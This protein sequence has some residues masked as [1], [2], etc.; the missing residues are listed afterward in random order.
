MLKNIKKSIKY[1]IIVL[2]VFIMLPTVLY[3]LLQTSSVQTFLVKRI[4]SHFSNQIKSTISIGSIE[5]RFFNKLSI[6][7]LLIKDRNNDTLIYSWKVMLGIKR[8]DFKKKSFRLGRV[9]LIKPV[10][11]FI[12]DSSGM[13][14]LTW[15]LNLLKNP[16]DTIKK[17]GSRFSVDQIDINDARFSLCLLYTSPS[18]RDS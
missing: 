5:Y 6:S 10:I 15:Y 14:N 2:G 3:L 12:T 8:L 16:S 18:P 11:A 7:D 1:F 9:S 13:M 17:T 4:T